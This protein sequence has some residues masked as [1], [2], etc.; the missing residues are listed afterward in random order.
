MLAITW[1]YNP[2]NDSRMPSAKESDQMKVL[3]DLLE[4]ALESAQ[5]AFLTVVVTGN[6]VREWQ[7]YSRD[8]A[9]SMNL[10]NKALASHSP[11]PITVSKQDDPEW[12]AYF[13]FQNVTG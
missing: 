7:W 1:K 13:Q 10:L 8:A 2:A 4:R 5:Q 9:E 11:F 12:E 6:G 3:E